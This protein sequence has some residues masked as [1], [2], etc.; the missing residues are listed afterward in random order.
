MITSETAEDNSPGELPKYQQ[1]N[2]HILVDLQ[3]PEI[4]ETVKITFT[5]TKWQSWQKQYNKLVKCQET[6]HIKS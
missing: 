3:T 1:Q 5:A 4:N 2:L 6:M